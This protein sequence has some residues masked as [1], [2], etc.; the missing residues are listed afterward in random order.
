MMVS[1]S[2]SPSCVP[3]VVQ[4]TEATTAMVARR[5]A[6]GTSGGKRTGPAAEVRGDGHRRLGAA[7]RNVVMESAGGIRA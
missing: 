6:A 1:V 2:A 5:C 7:W 4:V 3:L